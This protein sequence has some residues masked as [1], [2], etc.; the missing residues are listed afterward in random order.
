ML[1]K[2]IKACFLGCLLC[3]FLGIVTFDKW[4]QS[5][6]SKY[7]ALCY[8]PTKNKYT[9]ISELDYAKQEGYKT[10]LEFTNG[11]T[12]STTLPCTVAVIKGTS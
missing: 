8:D 1:K 9:L 5:N 10:T 7:S 3:L 12:M 11:N 6:N 2:L 4:S